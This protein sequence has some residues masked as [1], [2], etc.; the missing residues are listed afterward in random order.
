MGK[1]KLLFALLFVAILFI[2]DRLIGMVSH[3][4]LPKMT[5]GTVGLINKAVKDTSE[6]LVLGSSRAQNHY[7]S[8]VLQDVTDKTVFNAGVGGQG[9]LYCYAVLKER[10]KNQPPKIVVLD[11]APNIMVDDGQLEKLTTFNPEAD[12]YPAFGEIITLNPKNRPYILYSNAYKYNSTL[13]DYFFETVRGTNNKDGYTPL[14]GKINTAIFEPFYYDEASLDAEKL[15]KIES[16]FNLQMEYLYKIKKLCDENNIRLICVISPS[17][18]DH[19]KNG[20]FRRKILEGMSG[21]SIKVFDFTADK[22]LSGKAP[23]FRDQLHLNAQG[24]KMFSTA[25][26]DSINKTIKN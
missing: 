16:I 25:V 22:K 1:R 5:T 6:I 4:L 10:I 20:T 8:K 12:I 24:S 15:F 23:I 18:I 2:G 14:S 11:V 3:S 26:G 7:N 21:H 17:Y 13:F 9:V 19:D